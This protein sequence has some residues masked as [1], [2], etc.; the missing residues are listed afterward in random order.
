MVMSTSIVITFPASFESLADDIQR[1]QHWHGLFQHGTNYDDGAVGVN[2][3]PISP[4][5]SFLYKFSVPNQAGTYWYHSHDCESLLLSSLMLDLDWLQLLNI[6]MGFGVRSLS[7]TT[8]IPTKI[9]KVVLR[10]LEFLLNR[11]SQV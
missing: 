11:I 3:C 9:C 7:T 4:G 5:H 1:N 2:Q 10:T 8:K 6:V